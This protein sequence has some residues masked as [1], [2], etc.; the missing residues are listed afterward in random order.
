[1]SVFSAQ[2][3]VFD[4]RTLRSMQSWLPTRAEL[5]EVY[6]LLAKVHWCSFSFSLV[7]V[8]VRG[9]HLCAVVVKAAFLFLV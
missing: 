3:L 2:L 1:M 4:L 6:K 9:G 8:S 7:V 5:P